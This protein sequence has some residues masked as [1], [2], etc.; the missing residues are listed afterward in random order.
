MGLDPVIRTS[1]S[2]PEDSALQK[3]EDA[4]HQLKNLFNNLYGTRIIA[5]P[6]DTNLLE[7]FYEFQKTDFGSPS[8]KEEIYREFQAYRQAFIEYQGFFPLDTA[9][10]VKEH[11]RQIDPALIG[12]KRYDSSDSWITKIAKTVLSYI[13]RWSF[14][15][16]GI[17]RLLGRLTVLD[18]MQKRLDERE[19]VLEVFSSFFQTSQP[20]TSLKQVRDV[21][22]QCEDSPKYQ[23][24]KDWFYKYLSIHVNLNENFLLNQED[25][26]EFLRLHWNPTERVLLEGVRKGQAPIQNKGSYGSVILRNPTGKKFGV[27][28]A[29]NAH[30]S[31]LK[32]IGKVA[33][34]VLGIRDQEGYLPMPKSRHIAAMISERASY[35][36]DKTIG[37]HSNPQTEIIRFNGIRGSFQHF[38]HGY[39]EAEEVELPSLEDAQDSDLNKFQRFAILDFLQGNLDRKLDNWMVVITDDGKHF[40]DIKTIDNANCFPRGHLPDSTVL[41]GIPLSYDDK[42]C[43]AR[44]D[45][46]QSKQYLW[47]ELKL[48]NAPLTEE[49]KALIRSLT[50]EKIQEMIQVWKTDLGEDFDLFFGGENGEVIQAFRDRVK[51]LRKFLEESPQEPLSTLATYKSY[52]KIQKFLGEQETVA[53]QA[54][55]NYG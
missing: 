32:R 46:A 11:L 17:N 7:R 19:R 26:P 18:P 4:R 41:F 47:K 9:D 14:G 33:A 1:W 34:Y 24:R 40:K 48:A 45:L 50:E 22:N 13:S 55:Y 35:L 39:K 28:K 53:P 38:L 8:D 30:F 25:Y 52:S 36:L 31:F 23:G 3:L 44:V 12:E 16:K 51:I 37:T 10:S 27:Y 6:T 20:V 15:T 43:F 2:I 21:L 49:S 29:V 54:L 5:S 42:G